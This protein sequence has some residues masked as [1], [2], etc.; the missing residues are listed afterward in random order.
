MTKV[1]AANEVGKKY[2]EVESI[3][4]MFLVVSSMSIKAGQIISTCSRRL[5]T[6]NGGEKEGNPSKLPLIL[7]AEIID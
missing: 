6:P 1:V 4:D 5:V 7:G 3:Y 2:H